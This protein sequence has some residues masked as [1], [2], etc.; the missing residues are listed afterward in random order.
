LKSRTLL[1]VVQIIADDNSLNYLQQW[2][3]SRGGQDPAHT[4]MRLDH[5]RAALATVLSDLAHPS[6]PMQKDELSNIDR[7]GD[8]TMVDGVPVD[9]S[10][11]EVVTIPITVDDELSDIPA[12]M[13]E[14]VAREIAAFRDRSNRRDLERLK[15]EEEIESLE[16]ARNASG[17]RPSRLASPPLSAPSGPAGGANGIPIG[18]RDRSLLNAPA[19]PKGFGQQ[20][21]RDY[22]RGVTFVNGTGINGA[23]AFEDDDTDASDEE[24]ERRRKEK[25]N[26]ELEKQYV[27]QERRW[28]NRERSRTAAVEREKT[29]DEEEAARGDEEKEAMAKRLRE[30]NDD[31][32]ASRKVEEYYLDRSMW[33]RNRAAFRAREIALDDADRVAENRE[34]ARESQQRERAGAMADDFLDRQAEEMHIDQPRAEPTRFK[35]SLG[36]AA[37]KAQAATQQSRRIV[38]D[39]EGLLEDEEEDENTT[40]K[41]T[42]IPIQFDSTAE[43]AGLTDEERAQAARQLASDIPTDKDGLWRWDVKW[44]FVDD[45]V[46]GEQLKP[47]V[48]KKIVEY[49]GVQE[50]MLVD[51]VEA[52]LRKR[53]GP[54]ELVE[55]LEGVSNLFP[56]ISELMADLGV[57]ENRHWTKKQKCWLRSFGGWSSSSRNRR[58]VV[59]LPSYR[60]LDE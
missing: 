19:G 6:V 27:D 45:A 28:L 20:I 5:A 46:I 39:V 32:E 23:S 7:D 24:L 42:L 43:A 2:E 18:P 36:A 44:D 60:S 11:A 59:F 38:A 14:T 57:C 35:L 30:W 21:P 10:N 25:K 4:Q 12:E 8:I 48:E 33:I 56:M 1:T 54:G 40:G 31:G 41:R 29:R 16:R 47:F 26:A 3:E 17:P 50:Q 52:H 22:Q 37:Q 51:V 53:G 34:R 9:G 15:R 58:S 49:L 55:L 13:R